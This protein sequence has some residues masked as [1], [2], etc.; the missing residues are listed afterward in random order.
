MVRGLSLRG[1]RRRAA[2]AGAGRSARRRGVALILTLGVLALMI[3]LAFTFAVA[4]LNSRLTAQ[5]TYNLVQ[6]RLEAET[7]MQ[8]AYRDLAL[9]FAD[10]TDVRNLFPATKPGQANQF[11]LT[12]AS[13]PWDGRSYWCSTGTDRL[14]L[15]TALHVNLGGVDYTPDATAA[16]P[17][18]SIAWLNVKDLSG[19]ANLISRVCWLVIDESGRI[20]PSAVVDS[21]ASG[22]AEGSETD[23]RVGRFTTEINLKNVLTSAT[24]AEHFQATGLGAGEM[25]VGKRFFSF[26]HIFRQNREAAATPANVADVLQNL[27]PRSYDIE[28]TYVNGV[29]RHRFDLV[30]A[31]WDSYANQIPAGLLDTGAG[32]FWAGPSVVA[33][34]SGGINW[35]YYASDSVVRAQVIANLMDYCDADSIATSDDPDSPAYC[36]L[37]AVPYLNEFHFTGQMIVNGD[38]TFSL[39]LVL[40]PELINIFPEAH[41]AGGQLAVSVAAASDDFADTTI[42]FTWTGLADVP[43]RTYAVLA[44]VTRTLDVGTHPVLTGFRLRVAFA[45]LSDSA[46]GLWDAA[47]T[48]DTEQTTINPGVLRMVYAEVDDPRHNLTSD[49]WQWPATGWSPLALGTLGGRNTVCSPNPGAGH[50]LE[51]GA[52]EPWDV[53][54]AYLRNARMQSLWE[55]GAIHRAA[56]WQTINLHAYNS[57]A[58]PFTGLGAYDDGDANILDQVK[59]GA[60]T[61]VSGRVN[62]NTY[63]RAVLTGLLAGVTVG[64]TYAQPTGGSGTVLT[65]AVAQRVVGQLGGTLAAGEWLYENGASGAAGQAFHD[66]G[67]LARV[68]KLVDGSVFAQTTDAA[69]EEAL[70]KIVGLATTRMNYLTIVVVAQIIKDLDSGV[71]G[72]TRGV[73]DPGV[74]RILA[75]Q[76]ILAVLYRDAYTNRFRVERLDFL[77]N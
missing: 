36:G 7:T 51:T 54:T 19:S 43:G 2:A 74:D 13:A 12:T 31:A 77:S 9:A 73:Y 38:G 62:V 46:G 21:S 33:P 5:L 52:A 64:G 26:Y 8:L 67:A 30:N 14:E 66:R 60:T 71:Q 27:A 1:W 56:P 35:L 63:S 47:R 11:G 29:D 49:Q 45:K 69:Q 6:A 10:G 59:L 70:G 4:A 39:R 18:D 76:R 17:N 28:A 57:A 25:P 20:D 48:A 55:L 75:Q 68:A 16:L 58:T 50:D 15:E 40:T 3:V 65:A 22:V 34:P 41:G 32:E 37:E 44:P 61:L 72:G 53:S 23:S 42:A 24:L